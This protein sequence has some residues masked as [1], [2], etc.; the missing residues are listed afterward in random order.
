MEPDDVVHLA[1][2]LGRRVDGH[3]EHVA[4]VLPELLALVDAHREPPPVVVAIVDAFGRAWD[5]TAN[6]AVVPLAD[7]PDASVRS[8]VARALPGGV[9]TANGTAVVADALIRLSSDDAD[10]V[11]EWATFGLGT[12]LSLDTPEVR[13]A[14]FARLDDTSA[15]V[16]DEA[17]VG[18]ARRRHHG[19]VE[20]VAKRLRATALAR[21]CLGRP[22]FSA[23]RDCTTRSWTGRRVALTT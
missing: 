23:I 16:R 10:E 21:W 13:S 3:P 12:I 7:H 22:S 2:Q 9:E 11:R 15:I 4:D 19:V 6:L 14:L 8:A 20:R 18:L 1:G 5:E 17:L